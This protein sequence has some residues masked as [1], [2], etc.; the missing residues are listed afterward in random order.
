[1]AFSVLSNEPVRLVR[2]ITSSL[3]FS[4][5]DV[6]NADSTALRQEA[7][8]YVPVPYRPFVLLQWLRNHLKLHCGRCVGFQGWQSSAN[9]FFRVDSNLI[10]SETDDIYTV[11]LCG[12]P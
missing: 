10:P 8:T 6:L 1:M 3:L 4:P 2:P 11:R 5:S 9:K 7:S 12:G